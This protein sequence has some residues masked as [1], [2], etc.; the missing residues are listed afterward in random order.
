[1][2][3]VT[4]EKIKGLIKPD[5]LSDLTRLVLV[6]AVYFK[7]SWANKFDAK[8]TSEQVTVTDVRDLCP[9]FPPE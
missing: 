1:M 5:M 4:R 6:N 3:G 7:G 9:G 2:E 8:R